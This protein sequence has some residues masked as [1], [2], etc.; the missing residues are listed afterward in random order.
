MASLIASDH[1]LVKFDN[2]IAGHDRLL[3]LSTTDLLVIKPCTRTEL[4]FYETAQQYPEFTPWIPQC[5][6]SLR[7]STEAEKQLLNNEKENE[8]VVPIPGVERPRDTQGRALDDIL[9]WAFYIPMHDP[10]LLYHP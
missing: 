10:F 7:S 9:F 5:F 4:D 3:Q 1:Q 2:Q 8:G 6:G